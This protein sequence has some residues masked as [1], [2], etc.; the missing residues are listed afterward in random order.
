MVCARLKK[1]NPVAGRRKRGPCMKDVI[2]FLLD[3]KV[4][5]LATVE[6]DQPRVRPM[7]FAMDYE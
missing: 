5:Y 6:G 1:E 2:H 3:N 4:F 7:G